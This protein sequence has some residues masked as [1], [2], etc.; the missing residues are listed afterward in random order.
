MKKTLKNKIL[1]AV[2]L[3]ILSAVVYGIHFLIFHDFHHIM[4]YFIGDVGFVFIEV[5]L[6]S[7]II[8]QILSEREKKAMLSKLNMVIGAF[9]S[10]VG[11]EFLRY[12]I[13]FDKNPDHI[14][15]HLIVDKE[16]SDKHFYKMRELIHHREY[17]LQIDPQAL[18]QLRDFVTEKRGFLLRLLE[19][20]NLLEHESF[21]RLL[22]A[23][24]HLTEELS[25]RKKVL[26]LPD[27]DYT[28]LAGD[29]KRSYKLVLREW[30][31]HM[32]HLKKNYPY[33][34]SL[35]M[36]TNPFDPE[37]KVSVT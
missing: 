24:F 17:D 20:P 7:L 35:A 3:I 37:A 33:L 26:Q 1:L 10:E 5:L 21:T 12:C 9:Y 14:A 2:L 31:S 13:K 4:I 32:Q 22:W 11:T 15:K 25:N 6:V 34:F 27:T 29:I 36:R 23:V 18:K 28:H 8:H 16:W 19:N 30:I